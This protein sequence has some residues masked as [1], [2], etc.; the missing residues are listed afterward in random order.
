MSDNFSFSTSDKFRIQPPCY[1]CERRT[2]TCH[3][4]CPDYADY[5]AI[6]NEKHDLLVAEKKMADTIQGYFVERTNWY[7]KGE[8]KKR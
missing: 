4:D 6:I 2:M 8:K 7:R 1:K 3:D 5:K